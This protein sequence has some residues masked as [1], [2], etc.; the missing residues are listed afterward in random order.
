MWLEQSEQAGRVEYEEAGVRHCALCTVHCCVLMGLFL[1][2]E[3]LE[4]RGQVRLIH[5]CLMLEGARHASG[6]HR[7]STSK[8]NGKCQLMMRAL[9][10]KKK[11][12]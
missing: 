3:S 1:G 11:A 10:E 8:Q 6:G 12:R 4:V 7:W 9:K 2:P 5:C